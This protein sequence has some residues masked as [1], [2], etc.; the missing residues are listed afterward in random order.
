MRKSHPQPHPAAGMDCAD[1]PGGWLVA[2]S[3]ARPLL[4]SKVAGPGVQ[5]W[6][7]RLEAASAEDGQLGPSRDDQPTVAGRH[8][9]RTPT[10]NSLGGRITEPTLPDHTFLPAFTD[11]PYT[12]R[13][14]LPTYTT[15]PLK[16]GAMTSVPLPKIQRFGLPG[17]GRGDQPAV[18]KGVHAGAVEGREPPRRNT[19]ALTVRSGHS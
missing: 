18:L 16:T 11:T 6:G 9:A 12:V 13:F 7:S 3:A 14:L 19:E 4:A 8:A 1:L 10:P 5:G 17:W 15:P 2:C